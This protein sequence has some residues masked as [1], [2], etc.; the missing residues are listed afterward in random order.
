MSKKHHSSRA[1]A[2]NAGELYYFTGKPCANGHI[3]LRYAKAGACSE[4]MRKNSKDWICSNKERAAARDK[5]WKAK[6]RERVLAGNRRRY[7]KDAEWRREEARIYR[8]HNAEKSE[9]SRRA[10]YAKHREKYLARARL[11]KQRNKHLVS[12]QRKRWKDAN[13]DRI[14]A[15]LAT[16]K[17]HV[18]ERTPAWADIKAI[19]EFYRNR[20]EGYE[21]DHIIPL[22]GDR[23]SGL[24]ILENLQYLTAKENHVKNK[25][26]K[27]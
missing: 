24:H 25:F 26:F 6:N 3:A 4:C 18:K 8:L 23:V 22:R 14:R 20:P 27:V 12:A 15:Y 9:A 17:K 21:V 19:R 1:E 11:W 2:L 10:S 16:R 5:A 13:R 7:I